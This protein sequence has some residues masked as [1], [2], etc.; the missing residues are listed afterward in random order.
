[1]PFYPS[2]SLFSF[3]F[4]L[5]FLFIYLF[6]FLR[7]SSFYF[8][9]LYYLPMSRAFVFVFERLCMIFSSCYFLVLSPLYGI[10]LQS[11]F[12]SI[13]SLFYT[14]VT[15]F[16]RTKVYFLEAFFYLRR[17]KSNLNFIDLMLVSVNRI[18]SYSFYFYDFGR[19][20]VLQPNLNGMEN[21]TVYSS[22]VCVY[23]CYMLNVFQ[24]NH[25]K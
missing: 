24:G 6:I 25:E 9:Y 23:V 16:L 1:M 5:F 2:F 12:I 7:F 21:V 20:V 10:F 11:H 13:H 18:G 17:C 14:T 8:Q 19:I 4:S 15:I 22:F 3:F